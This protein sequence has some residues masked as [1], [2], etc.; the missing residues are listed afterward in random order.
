[1]RFRLPIHRNPSNL[2]MRLSRQKPYP[3]I[4]IITVSPITDIAFIE[5]SFTMR[6]IAAFILQPYESTV[7][8][9]LYASGY[10]IPVY[11][12]PDTSPCYLTAIDELHIFCR[13]S[14]EPPL[15]MDAFDVANKY[16]EIHIIP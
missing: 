7:L 4:G 2:T 11:F 6:Q 5:D 8:V 12:I 15:I 3:V 9:E 1:M 10:N 13:S 14:D 16:V